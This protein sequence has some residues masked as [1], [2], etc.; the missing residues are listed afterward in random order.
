MD[1]DKTGLL[2][3]P[4]EP[5]VESPKKFTKMYYK[6]STRCFY[7]GTCIRQFLYSGSSDDQEAEGCGGRGGC[8]TEQAGAAALR[9]PGES[10]DLPGHHL[11]RQTAPDQQDDQLKP[12]KLH[13][14]LETFVQN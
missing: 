6:V 12:Q 5:V 9:L 8:W 2:S 13:T 4:Q 1:H 3:A 11:R 14:F 7:H 10:G